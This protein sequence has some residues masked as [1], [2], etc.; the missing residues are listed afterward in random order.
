MKD[1]LSKNDTD[2]Y[3]RLSAAPY[4]KATSAAIH[5]YTMDFVAEPTNSNIF[6]KAVAFVGTNSYNNNVLSFYRFRG[7]TNNF[8]PPSKELRTLRIDIMYGFDKKTG[9][10][11]MV[12]TR[13]DWVYE[14]KTITHMNLYE[15]EYDPS[16]VITKPVVVAVEHKT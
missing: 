11:L 14:S 12:R 8:T 3:K 9:D 1:A 16:I 10:L 2:T 5:S 7:S 13:H 4:N 15:W 6:D